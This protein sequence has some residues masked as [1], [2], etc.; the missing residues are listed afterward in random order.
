MS[1]GGASDEDNLIN[2]DEDATL[3]ELLGVTPDC[4]E[5]TLRRA[6]KKQALRWH[7]D[8]CTEPDAEQTFKRISAAFQVLSNEAQRAQYD[9]EL[10]Y[11]DRCRSMTALCWRTRAF[12]G[13][14]WR[15]LSIRWSYAGILL[16]VR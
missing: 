3:Y 12:T 15:P 6:Y 11:G 8:K 16:A 9:H 2:L 14:H 10:S 4:D 5:T 13:V 1:G 7:P